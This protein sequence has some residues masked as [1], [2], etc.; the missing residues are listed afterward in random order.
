[1]VPGNGSTMYALVARKYII[2]NVASERC[3][4]TVFFCPMETLLQ[5]LFGKRSLTHGAIPLFL[6]A[7]TKGLNIPFVRLE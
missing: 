4:K 3:A 5:L 6:E 1:M 7:F 2:E